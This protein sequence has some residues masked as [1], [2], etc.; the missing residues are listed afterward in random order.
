[1][2]VIYIIQ[3]EPLGDAAENGEVSCFHYFSMNLR[4]FLR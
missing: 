3:R 1:M 2:P 4:Q